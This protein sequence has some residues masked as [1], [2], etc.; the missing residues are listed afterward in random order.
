MG[1]HPIAWY[2]EFE[3][4]RAWYT[5]LGHPVELYSD[6]TFTRHVLGGIRWAAGVAP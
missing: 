1:D 2:H 3:G 6:P 5:A 4:G